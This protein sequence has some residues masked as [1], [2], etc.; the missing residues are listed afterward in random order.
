MRGRTNVCATAFYCR[1]GTIIGR[2]MPRHRPRPKILI[3]CLAFI[4][5]VVALIAPLACT[6]TIIPPASPRQPEKIYLL[7]HG[8]TSSLLLPV[9]RDGMIRYAYG[10]WNYY[11]LANN[12]LLDGLAALFWPTQGTLGRMQ[13]ADLHDEAAVQKHFA[14][15]TEKI[16]A[17]IVDHGDVRRLHDRLEMLYQNNLATLVVNRPYNLN[18]V[19][20]PQKYSYLHNSNYLT[21]NWLRDLGCRVR[22]HPINARW[23]VAP[24]EGKP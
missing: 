4:L 20:H 6:T 21:A 12:G 9:E 5:A 7:D 18:F 13:Y 1:P 3:P 14:K 15:D 23:R 17:V 22:R 11:A 24:P 10:D 2:F 8:R 19:H 16:H